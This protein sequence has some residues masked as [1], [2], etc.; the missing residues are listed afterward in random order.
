MR[1]SKEFE[2]RLTV[3]QHMDGLM[4]KYP[5]VDR[6]HFLTIV[7]DDASGL[8]IDLLVSEGDWRESAAAIDWMESMPAQDA[9]DFVEEAIAVL[10]D[11]GIRT[12]WARDFEER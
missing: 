4:E 3:G 6:V 8:R 1:D 2:Y 9:I 7:D 10:E 12:R 11:R 5:H